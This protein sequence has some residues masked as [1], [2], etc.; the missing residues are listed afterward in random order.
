MRAGEDAARAEARRLEAENPLW[1]VIFGVY[2]GEFACLPRFGLDGGSI[3]AAKN[4][5]SL[6]PR[7]RGVEHSVLTP[8][9]TPNSLASPPS[10]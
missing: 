5:G 6:P 9:V 3:V 10:R 7:M 4:P 1:I 2:S 8:P